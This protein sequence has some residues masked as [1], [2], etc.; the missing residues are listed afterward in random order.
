MSHNA[1]QLSWPRRP[2]TGLDTLPWCFSGLLRI[3]A[4]PS[5]EFAAF[6]ATKCGKIN[7]STAEL[8]GR[9]SSSGTGLSVRKGV[10]SVP[11]KDD[12][13]ASPIPRRSDRALHPSRN[14]T[15]GKVL[16]QRRT[17]ARSDW[18]GTVARQVAS[19]RPH[20]CLA[21]L[22]ACK[23]TIIGLEDG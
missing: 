5:A 15:S 16:N 4:E 12:Q 22:I 9:V 21:A 17:F 2:P 10:S 18:Q 20:L 14:V 7:C 8:V 1:A 11:Q 23:T 13:Y 19:A 6:P 3:S